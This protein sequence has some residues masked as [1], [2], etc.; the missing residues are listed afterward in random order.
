[1]NKNFPK[2]LVVI[3]LV[4]VLGIGGYYFRDRLFPQKEETTESDKI[5]IIND[6]T[7]SYPSGWQEESINDEEK[8]SGIIEKAKRDDLKSSFI[9]RTTVGKL[10]ENLDIQGLPDLIV[11][12]MEKEVFGFKLVKKEVTKIDQY[13]AIN[14]RYKQEYAEVEKN[15][16][17]IIIIIATQY[18]TFYLIFRGDESTFNQIDNN[19]TDISNAI[20]KY[21]NSNL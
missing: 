5:S 9:L 13:E 15:Q 2:L 11:K 3:G 7:V 14:I 16:E 10:E 4:V 6:M 21:L 18:Q 12:S 17:N 1:M 8:I 20:G 19:V